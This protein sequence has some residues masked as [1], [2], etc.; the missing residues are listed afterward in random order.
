MS[1]QFYKL[2]HVSGLFLLFLGL[3]W[4]FVSTKL[5][6][7]KPTRKIGFALHGIGL[8]SVFIS[9]FGLAARLGM[10]QQLPGWVHLKITIWVLLALS[11]MAIKRLQTFWYANLALVLLLGFFAA[12]SAVYKPF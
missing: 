3:G 2:L 4:I 1:Y 8:A 11:V 12:Y 9:G 10:V 5:N 7:L 6:E